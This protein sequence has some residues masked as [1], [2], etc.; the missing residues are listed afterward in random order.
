MRR[1]QWLRLMPED[2]QQA[3]PHLTEDIL[4]GAVFC[5]NREREFNAEL[6]D[7]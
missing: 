7:E 6:D 4:A 5:V 1:R 2:P 3:A